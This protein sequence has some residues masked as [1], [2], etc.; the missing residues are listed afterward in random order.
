MENSTTQAPQETSKGPALA[1]LFGC[2]G[3]I[4]LGIL[5]LIMIGGI[6]YFKG[7]S[8]PSIF[9]SATPPQTNTPITTLTYTPTPTYTVSPTFTAI[10]TSTSSPIP[11]ATFIFHPPTMGPTST[12]TPTPKPTKTRQPTPTKTPVI[13]VINDTQYDF[14]FN[15]WTGIDTKLAYGKGMR[16]S[17]TEDEI[18]SFETPS[19]AA[20]LGLMFYKGPN[21]GQ[22]MILVDNIQIEI[23]DLYSKLPLY[24]YEW[25]YQFAKPYQAHKVRVRILH[26]KRI[27]S[28]GYKICFDGFRIGTEFTDDTNYSIRYGAWGGL[29]NG[30]ALGGGYRLATTANSSVTFITR[31]R[32]FQ[33]ITARGPN[34]GQAV[35]YVDAKA[36]LTVDLYFPTQLWQQSIL[37]NNLGPGVHTISI[38]LLGQNQPASGGSGVVFD[39]ILIP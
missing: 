14:G 13:T 2:L 35:I 4:L 37:V 39:G 18:L 33:W 15:T 23:L 7:Y 20:S 34:Y 9:A 30:N 11:T 29:W 25:K 28:T 17:S 16:C 6:V 38:V 3:I 32:S 22:A 8:P 21:Q 5:I 26:E 27:T 19:N 31:G 24:R 1:I 36:V 12:K 10:Q